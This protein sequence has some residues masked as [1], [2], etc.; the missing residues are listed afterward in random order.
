MCMFLLLSVYSL[1]SLVPS[2]I[3]AVCYFFCVCL[4]LDFLSVWLKLTSTG[5]LILYLGLNECRRHLCWGIISLH[6]ALT[7]SHFIIIIIILL[8]LFCCCWFSL[9]VHASP[10]NIPWQQIQ[11]Y[12]LSLSYSISLFLASYVCKFPVCSFLIR[13]PLRLIPLAKKK[14]SFG[15]FSSNKA[16]STSTCSIW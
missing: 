14:R 15:I 5:T 16:S 13:V 12:S 8:L 4:S 6:V 9:L 3:I 2:L 10:I 7:Q 1:P 11:I